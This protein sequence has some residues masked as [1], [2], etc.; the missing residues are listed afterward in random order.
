[1]NYTFNLVAENTTQT[2]REVCELNQYA[3]LE[4]TSKIPKVGFYVS[5]IIMFTLLLW[6]FVQPRF[7]DID[8]FLGLEP[9]RFVTGLSI[10]L[11]LILLY[12]ALDLS[13]STLKTIESILYILLAVIGVAIA[14]KFYK[15][16]QSSL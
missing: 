13:E 6:F 3:L 12:T 9:L 5:F 10:F 14:Y 11:T 15:V 1:M 16:Y 4:Q 7:K 2:F 8:E